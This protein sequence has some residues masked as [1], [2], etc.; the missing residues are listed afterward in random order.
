[1]LNNHLHDGHF[2]EYAR[3]IETMLRNSAEEYLLSG[4]VG[5]HI[6]RCQSAPQKDEN[7]PEW[8]FL[9]KLFPEVLDPKTRDV[10]K[11]LDA[12]PAWAQNASA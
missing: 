6:T 12:L 2:K 8:R 3:L 11:N 10:L 4:T 1:M 9:E 5:E 7:S